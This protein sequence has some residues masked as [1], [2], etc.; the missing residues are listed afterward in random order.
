MTHKEYLL[1]VV[2]ASAPC[3]LRH[4][5]TDCKIQGFGGARMVK[6]LHEL[7]RDHI[8][9]IDNGDIELGPNWAQL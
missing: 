8:V 5:L 9:D 1:T 4:V 3:S 7:V 2:C 6:A